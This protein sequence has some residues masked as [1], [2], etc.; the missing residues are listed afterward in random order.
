[1]PLTHQ[2]VIHNFSFADMTVFNHYGQE[3]DGDLQA[4]EGAGGCLPLTTLLYMTGGF[5]GLSQHMFM[6]TIVSV[7]FN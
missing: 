4:G 6:C 2:L 7:G 5:T 1:M 3:P